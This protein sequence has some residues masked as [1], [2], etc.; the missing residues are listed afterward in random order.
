ME[1]FGGSLESVLD[2]IKQLPKR[3]VPAGATDHIPVVTPRCPLRGRL[4]LISAE[5]RREANHW[6]DA[7]M[8]F[9]ETVW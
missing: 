6:I 1:Y 4:H 2:Y 5:R 7:R 3:E 8:R 9:C